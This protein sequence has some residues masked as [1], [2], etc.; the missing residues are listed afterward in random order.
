MSGRARW[1][2]SGTS[3]EPRGSAAVEF[4][5]VL[6]LVLTM[7]LVIL[8]LSLVAKDR[9]I[10]QDGARAGAREA[11]V[12]SDD[13][14]VRSAVVQA[15]A[16]FDAS[17]LTVQVSRQGGVG[18]PVTVTVS[19]HAS[20]DIPVVQWLLPSGVDLTAEATMRQEGG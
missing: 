13:A 18:T 12:S 6:P 5:L 4:A 7:A 16:G 10:L 15:S 14:T 19:Y 1:R 11:S 2:G 8:E 9:L 17:S 3:G 20:I